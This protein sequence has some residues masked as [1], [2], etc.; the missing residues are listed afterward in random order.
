M[1]VAGLRLVISEAFV[2]ISC[3]AFVG[4][5]ETYKETGSNPGTIVVA[6]TIMSALPDSA[7]AMRAA[8]L[9]KGAGQVQLNEFSRPTSPE[10]RQ[11]VVVVGLGMVGISFM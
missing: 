2:S 3:A 7:P 6:K 8:A 1:T 11:R 10:N 5:S 9:P 4:I